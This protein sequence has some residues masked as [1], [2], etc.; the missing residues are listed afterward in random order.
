M[1]GERGPGQM[2]HGLWL[3][4]KAGRVGASSKALVTWPP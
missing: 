1:Q 3:L 4:G 2:G